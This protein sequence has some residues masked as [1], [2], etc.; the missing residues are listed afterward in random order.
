MDNTVVEHMVNQG[1]FNKT[2]GEFLT[3]Q[4]KVNKAFSLLIIACGVCL[5]FNNKKISKLTSEVKELKQMKG[6]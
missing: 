3:N 5:Y 1:V 6:A 4:E 2:V